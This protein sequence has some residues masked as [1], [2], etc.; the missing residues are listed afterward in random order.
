VEHGLNV[1]VAAEAGKGFGK[2]KQA[3]IAHHKLD[4][5]KPLPLYLMTKRPNFFASDDDAMALIAEIE[6][7]RATYAEPLVSIYL[8]TLSALTPGMNE[9]AS[10]DISLVRMR[11]EKLRETFGV[12][13]ILVHHKP[14]GGSTPRGH[15]S[16]TGDFETT[17]EFEKGEQRDAHGRPV[18]RATVRKQREG[19]SGLSWQFTLPVVEV[20]RNKWGNPETSCVVQPF[21]AATRSKGG[22]RATSNEL[23]FLHALFEALDREG[24]APPRGLPRSITR[25]VDFKHVREEMRRRMIDPDGDERAENQR[26]RTAFSRAG[27]ELRDGRIIGVDKPLV[28]FTGK[29]VHGL[30]TNAAPAAVPDDP[31]SDDDAKA[32]K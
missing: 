14:K 16:L 4:P 2:R 29:A 24:V 22:F 32:L 15:G 17:I 10:Q 26:F 31:L 6:A 19:K 27:K 20:G 5:T 8:D 13:V 9:N 3:Y 25:A 11:L 21:E 18:H 23:L 30:S 28:W 12:S 1:Y 7:V